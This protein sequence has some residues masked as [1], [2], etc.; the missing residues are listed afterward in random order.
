MPDRL[1]IWLHG[2]RVARVE[3]DRRHRLRLAYTPEA[4]EAFGLGTP[5]LSIRLPVTGEPY[6]NAAT[7]AFLDGL[8]PEGEP[9]RVLAEDLRLLADDTFG[10]IGA[11]GR[12]CAGALVIQPDREPPPPP[13]D[14]LMSDP[15]GEDDLTKLV[16]NL[17]GAP[18]GIDRRVRVSLAGMQ[19]KLLLTRRPD[20]S[21]GRPVN[22]TPST[23]ILKPAIERFHH[24]VENEA[25]CL[26]LAGHLGLLVAEAGVVT[27]TGG[28]RLLVVSRYDRLVSPDG[29]VERLHQEDFCQATG[30]QPRNKYQ[31]AGGP[32]LRRMADILRSVDPESLPRLLQGVTLN[33]LIA[34]GDAHAKNFSLLHERPGVLRLAPLYDL[35]T[36]L[37]YGDDRLAMYVDGVQRTVRVTRERI[38][39]E[40]ASWGMPRAVAAGVVDD[41]VA[42]APEA[43]ARAAADVP[44]LPDEFPKT[45]RSQLHNLRR[46]DARTPR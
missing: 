38:L 33:V 19:E 37:V 1:A 12:D 16:A 42:R 32:S 30:T 11:L 6:S 4:L 20:G 35:M 10:L 3:M 17:R 23:H 31:E 25:F 21:W 14:T 39:N 26:R 22:G 36:T 27:T 7:T 5:L 8:L 45:V 41:L 34:N 9:R 13:A 43:V 18:L 29:A 28:H 40:A 15:V 24:T 2:T 44:G 46:Y